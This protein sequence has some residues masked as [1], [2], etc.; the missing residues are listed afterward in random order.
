MGPPARLGQHPS[1]D[2]YPGRVGL[3]DDT[4]RPARQRARRE[5]ELL[6]VLDEE[7]RRRLERGLDCA[8]DGMSPLVEAVRGGSVDPYTAALRILDDVHTLEQL[9]GRR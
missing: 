7:L 5:G 9:L 1:S 4:D 2:R 8:A 3:Q 6:D